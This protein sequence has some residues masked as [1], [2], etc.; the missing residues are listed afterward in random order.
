MISN[1]E[2]ESGAGGLTRVGYYVNQRSLRSR[3]RF[4]ALS[5]SGRLYVFV[6]VGES[7][8]TTCVEDF[9]WDS[10]RSAAF[11]ATSR[12]DLQ[13]EFLTARVQAAERYLALV[14]GCQ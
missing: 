3:L 11:V 1:L 2:N 6:V 13:V 14:M 5:A 9:G 7:G 10:E 12:I 8:A 4:F